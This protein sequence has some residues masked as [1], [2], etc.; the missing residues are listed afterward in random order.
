MAPMPPVDPEITLGGYMQKHDRAAAFTG[1]DGQAYSVGIWVDEA[2]DDRGR[3]GAALIFVRWN[4]AGDHPTGHV[5]TD[6][7]AWGRS[8]GDAEDR[9]RALT[10]YDV[11]AALDE[12]IARRG[13]EP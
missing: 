4:P 1:S 12:A 3:Y 9:L 13:D 8:P 11:K 10:L 6:Y 7:L 2:P 5:E